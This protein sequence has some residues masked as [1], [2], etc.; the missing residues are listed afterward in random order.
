MVDA[1][2][3]EI[4]DEQGTGI[5]FQLQGRFT[6]IDARVVLNFQIVH[7]ELAPDDHGGSDDLDPSA[8]QRILPKKLLVTGVN[9]VMIGGI[10]ELD[11]FTV[12]D[13]RHRY[14]YTAATAQA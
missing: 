5:A 10:V 9:P 12:D 8:I 14:P 11:N 3:A 7:G 13:E 4:I 6:D 1:L 2:T